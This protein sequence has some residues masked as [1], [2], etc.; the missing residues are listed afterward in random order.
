[1]QITVSALAL[2]ATF[3]CLAADARAQATPFRIDL[4][5]PIYQ[6]GDNLVLD[7]S[8]APGTTGLLLADV[9]PGPTFVPGIGTFQ[10]GFT[11]QLGSLIIPPL[12]PS[13][14]RVTCGTPCVPSGGESNIYLQAL[15]VSL[16]APNFAI[17]NPTTLR[18]QDPAGFCQPS[19]CAGS[20]SISSNF[21]GT[22]IAGGRYV[23]F[24]AVAKLPGVA[25]AGTVRVRNAMVR[26]ESNGVPYTVYLPDTT[27]IVSPLF[28]EA[29]VHFEA[30]SN[31]WRVKVP[32]GFSGNVFLGGGAFQVPA[33]GLP[34][35]TNPVA[36][37]FDVTSNRNTSVQW[38]WAAAVYTDF[39]SDYND[40]DVAPT[41]AS[42]THAGVPGSSFYRQFV[43]G[44]ARGGGGSNF[45]GSYSGTSTFQCQ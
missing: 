37:S 39:P 18:V 31:E 45:S 34:G 8:G 15:S 42:G 26:F 12:P 38:K 24:N 27:V 3:W 23:W 21:N 13:G 14:F 7:I 17:S 25:N 9:T 19:V 30:A 36:W 11:P 22:A 4:S 40:L 5:T 43:V 44:G 6:A 28:S 20:D 2:S 1:M 16:T 29:R 35:G 41:D 10:L 32:E 33:S